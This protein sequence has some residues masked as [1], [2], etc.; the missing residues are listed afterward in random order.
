MLINKIFANKKKSNE[1]FNFYAWYSCGIVIHGTWNTDTH[2]LII[3]YRVQQCAIIKL[4]GRKINFN[5]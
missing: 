4:D 3:Y 1:I 5:L 2:D